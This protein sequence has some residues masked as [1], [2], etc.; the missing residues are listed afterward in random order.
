VELT[1]LS[2]PRGEVWLLGPAEGGAYVSSA[3][4][5]GPFFVRTGAVRGFVFGAVTGK[6]NEAG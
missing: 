2:S 4:E 3:G 5:A 6:L 1:W